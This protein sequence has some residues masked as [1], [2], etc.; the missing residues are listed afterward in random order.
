MLL[1]DRSLL[2]AEVEIPLALVVYVACLE[3]SCY[4]SSPRATVA[5]RRRL[6][7]WKLRLRLLLLSGG[8]RLLDGFEVTAGGLII[9]FTDHSQ[10]APIHKL[11]LGLSHL[12]G[13]H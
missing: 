13:V 6:S 10:K 3:L 2:L 12:H 5:C 8:G 9:V 1:T 7:R 11:L 4:V